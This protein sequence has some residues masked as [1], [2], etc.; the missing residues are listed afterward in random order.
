M[1]YVPEKKIAWLEKQGYTVNA[2]RK[3]TDRAPT[4]AEGARAW[5]RLKKGRYGDVIWGGGYLTTRR[6]RP[7]SELGARNHPDISSAL[8]CPTSPGKASLP[9]NSD[10]QG[11]AS[12]AVCFVV[13]CTAA[14]GAAPTSLVYFAMRLVRAYRDRTSIRL[15]SKL[16]TAAQIRDIVENLDVVLF[17]QVESRWPA[18]QHG[19]PPDVAEEPA[20]GS[21][22]S[23]PQLHRCRSESE[24][25]VS[26]GISIATSPLRRSRARAIRPDYE[27]YIGTR[28][29]SEPETRNV[30]WLLDRF[31]KIRYLFDLHSYGETILHNWG[32]DEN[33]AS[34]K[35]N[36]FSQQEVRRQARPDPRRGYREHMP[37]VDERAAQAMGDTSPR[38][39]SACAGAS[40]RCR[41]RLAFIHG[42][43][44][45]RLRVI[46]ATSWIRR[47]KDSRVHD[48][49]GPHPRGHP[50]SPP[51]PEMRK[52]MREVTAGLLE[53]C[54]RARSI[55]R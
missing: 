5:W 37:R 40:T 33:Q 53:C 31:P 20:P 4:P 41:N 54:L 36:E 46:A 8:R 23:W 51:Y 35:R 10:R 39:S 12:S 6:S 38:P 34:D 3:S 26:C 9:R 52:V 27:T 14:S 16:F 48:G 2:R 42:R 47:R 1:R 30:I 25:S 50:V 17:P 28:A 13:A 44:D 45:R 15:G 55:G 49:V 21:T 11:R 32:S 24:L 7:R 22:R 19:A 18:L 29:A 43:V